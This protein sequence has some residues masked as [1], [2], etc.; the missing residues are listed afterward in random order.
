MFLSHLHLINFKNYAEQEIDFAEKLN[1]FVGNNGTGKTNLLDA[2]Y[3]LSFCKSY[4][5]FVDNQNIRH[6]EDF[7]ALHGD[8][9][10][11][12]EEHLSERVS[13][14]QQHGKPKQMRF[15][16]KNYER[17]S[18]HIGKIPLVIISPY[19]Q[20]LING[21]SDLRRKFL[22]GMISQV[23]KNYL[24]L[25]MNYQKVLEQR[26][27]LLKQFYENRYFD[28]NS[29]EIWDEQLV[30][31]G[32]PIQEI[33]LDFL[34]SFSG[35]FQRN[36]ALI[37]AEVSA[38]IPSIEYSS[39]F[40]P[41]MLQAALNEAQRK[42][43]I[44]QYTSVGAHKDDLVFCING[45]S[46]KKTA[47]QGQQKTFLLALKLAQFEYI[48]NNLK[49]KPLLLLDDVFDKLDLDRVKHLLKLVSG[50]TFG[51]VFL[52]DTQKNRVEALLQEIA[53][54]CKMFS[55]R[56]NTIISD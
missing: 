24:E 32:E 23:D 56:D 51:Q 18:D 31:L 30:R 50:E 10:F 35:Y 26:N 1:C 48:A 33:R 36:F 11:N 15:N 7:F 37:S 47:S 12:T 25:L 54:D 6:G 9:I 28:Q 43:L 8:Y 42:D 49:Q 38:E 5:N 34:K 46:V 27:K 40:T 2:V 41:K 21:G 4:F 20:D 45:Y 39:S 53:I 14:I 22:D 55:V 52:T 16:K 44:L 19:D 29:L 17:F 13:C 3:Y